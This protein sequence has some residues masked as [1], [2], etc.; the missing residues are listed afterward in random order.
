MQ[1]TVEMVVVAMPIIAG[2]VAVVWKAA[3]KLSSIEGKVD[4]ALEWISEQKNA[5]LSAPAQPARKR[6]RK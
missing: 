2:T 6:S 4:K 3:T 5:A 1:L